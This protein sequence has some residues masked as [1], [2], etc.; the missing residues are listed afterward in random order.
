MTNEE[1]KKIYE[2]KAKGLTNKEIS[3]AIGVNHE[4]IK[5]FLQRNKSVE[6]KPVVSHCETCGAVISQF[7]DGRTKRF[8]SPK[9]RNDYWNKRRKIADRKSTKQ[10]ECE[11]CHKLFLTYGRPRRFCSRTCFQQNE[12]RK[13]RNGNGQN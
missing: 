6:I 7:T 2:L 5:K 4:T 9:C 3:V 10:C 12:S 8:C 1:I 13:W 11:E